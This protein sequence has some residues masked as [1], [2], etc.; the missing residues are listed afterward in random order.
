VISVVT[1]S[2]AIGDFYTCATLLKE[3]ARSKLQLAIRQYAEI[4]ADSDIYGLTDADLKSALARSDKKIGQMTQ[5]VGQALSDGTPI[6]VSLTNSLNAVASNQALR[7]AAYNEHLH[8]TI[9]LLL[10]ISAIVTTLLLGRE[11]GRAD[12]YEFAGTLCFILLVCLVVYVSLDLNLPEGGMIGINQE[13][14]KRLFAS[15]Q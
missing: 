10:F 7:L 2:N 13:P 9:V 4:R 15:M 1:D 5:L 3:P 6:S 12:S 11:Q 14:M 8:H